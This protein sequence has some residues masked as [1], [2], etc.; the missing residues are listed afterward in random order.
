MN[1]RVE[2]AQRLFDARKDGRSVSPLTND[3]PDLTVEE[4]YEIQDAF[5]HLLTG[6]GSPVAAIKLGLTSRAKQEQMNVDEPLYGVMTED[7]RFDDGRIHL[8]RFVQPRAEPEIAFLIGSELQGNVTRADVLA[9]TSAVMP[10]VD[11]LDSRFSGYSF[12]L[13][14]VVA[15]DASAA[16][17]A[18]GPSVAPVDFELGL[19]G[20]VFSVNGEIVATAA[21]AAALGHPADSVAWLVRKMGERGRSLA[22]DSIVLSGALTSAV[23]LHA[24]DH[25]SVD[26]DRVGSIELQVI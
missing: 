18:V 7:M 12:N 14:D 20:C 19:V 17:F 2:L 25:L 21:G 9:A 13:A 22:A 6:G 10:A 5:V 15:D 1:R 16:A 23:V 11:I 4:A 26:I 8:E 24:G 3:L